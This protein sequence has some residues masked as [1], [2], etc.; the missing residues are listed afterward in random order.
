MPNSTSKR[1]Q[2]E[3]R[4]LQAFTS[5]LALVEA[6]AAIPDQGETGTASPIT[7]AGKSLADI[8]S[9]VLGCQYVIVYALDSP[10][11]CHRVWGLSG[12]TPEQ[13]QRLRAEANQTPLAD[14][15]DAAI[16]AKLHANQVVVFDLAHQPFVT[17]RATFGARYRLIAPMVLH[18]QLIGLL[19]M[20]KTDEICPDVHSAY[21]SEE[22]ALARGV[23]KLTAL[24]IERV[25]LLQ[26]WAKAHANELILQETNRRKV[27]Q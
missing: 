24:V 13:E 19:V 21:S 6:M 8:T 7:I 20:A 16:I 25:H 4:N 9:Q 22:V 11:E 23:A 1:D 15:L 26:E 27:S 17:S 12:F 5:L 2:K 18:D 3:S 14:Y 10:N